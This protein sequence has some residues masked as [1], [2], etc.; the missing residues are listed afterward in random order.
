MSGYAAGAPLD[1]AAALEQLQNE[2]QRRQQLQAAANTQTAAFSALARAQS[3]DYGTSLLESQ[4]YRTHP[5]TAAVGT[6]APYTRA[7]NP[8]SAIA[9]ARVATAYQASPQV[10]SDATLA[11]SLYGVIGA[12]PLPQTTYAYA[13]PAP[14]YTTAAAYRPVVEQR[15]GYSVATGSVATAPAPYDAYAA[16]TPY[17]A[18]TA[19]PAAA[20]SKPKPV[21]PNNPNKPRSIA[22]APPIRPQSRKREKKELMQLPKRT[23]TKDGKILVNDGATVYYTGCLPLGLDDDKY[24][25]SELQ[26][27]LREN[28]GE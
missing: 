20:Y 12:R 19:S 23:A 13:S 22:K 11:S 16:T 6:T 15:Y 25:L 14:T 8:Y 10:T 1:D 2:Y 4:Y 18:A 7:T 21:D 28:F 27:Y 17:S 26:V 9:D 3:T 5:V 24:W